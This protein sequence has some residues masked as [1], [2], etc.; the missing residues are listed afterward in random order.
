VSLLDV[1]LRDRPAEA[2]LRNEQVGIPV[3]VRKFLPELQPFLYKLCVLQAD[4][5]RSG[6]AALQPRNFYFD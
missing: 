1:D 3:G 5:I 6:Y 2:P 4:R